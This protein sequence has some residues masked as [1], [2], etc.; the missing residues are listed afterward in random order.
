MRKAT[1]NTLLAVLLLAAVAVPVVWRFVLWGG[2]D[3]N[4]L[5]RWGQ[6]PLAASEVAYY[7]SRLSDL[8]DIWHQTWQSAKFEE[9][10]RFT[11]SYDAYLVVDTTGPA[12]WI[13]ERGQVLEGSR[14]ELPRQLTWRLYHDEGKGRIPLP[15]VA[16]F[17]ARGINTSQQWPEIL[18]LTGRSG[19]K[20]SWITYFNCSTVGSDY[21]PL[22]GTITLN[23]S[24]SPPTKG[25]AYYPSIVVG[26]DE[27]EQARRA[28]AGA[29]GEAPRMERRPSDPGWTAWLRVEKQLYQEIENQFQKAGF[30]PRSMEI[31]TGPDRRAAHATI[32]G[33]CESLIRRYLDR[34]SSTETHLAIDWVGE[35]LWYVKSVPDP[36]WHGARLPSD[37]LEM[38][39]LVSANGPV[40]Q[41][42]VDAWL[43]KGRA[44]QK[45]VA[46]PSSPWRAVLP[47]GTI[48]ELLG[49]C[50]PRSDRGW[51]G[52]DGR[53]LAE[54]PY[55]GDKPSG[56]RRGD[57]R[58]YEIAWKMQQ[59]AGQPGL[60][61]TTMIDGNRGGY[62]RELKD[63]YGNRI[64]NGMATEG[65]IFNEAQTK[66]TLTVGIRIADQ[67]Y[68]YARFKNISLV[69]GT[70]QGFE[71]EVTSGQ[72]PPGIRER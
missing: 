3:N 40:P 26:E 49:L 60:Q 65:V 29:D 56:P 25:L 12:L 22:T 15:A 35:D 10:G 16:R 5:V 48:I 47:N 39:F 21:A 71:I 8:H 41:A 36:R 23:W 7:R 53:G 62:S 64:L 46:E 72:A 57:G 59:P 61:V 33:T 52:P 4:A 18:W 54:A 28:G 20:E 19:T 55:A 9:D 63:R 70:N 13:E 51:W 32:H 45:P 66:T 17:Q 11:P 34:L 2:T 44:R 69:P 27:Y 68:Q 1:R 24:K 31:K 14:T 43:A 58:V 50:E 30:T 38:E 67:D 37:A 6:D 42:Q